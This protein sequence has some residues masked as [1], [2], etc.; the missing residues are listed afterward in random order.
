MSLKPRSLSHCAAASLPYVATTAWS[1]LVVTAELAWERARRDARVL[2]CGA[3]G[4][5]GT[6]A[7]QLLKAWGC[8]VWC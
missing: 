7:V 4:G 6:L 3:A 2:V 1:A 8:E 5:V